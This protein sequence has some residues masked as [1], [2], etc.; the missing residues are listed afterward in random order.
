[1]AGK[2]DIE[3]LFKAHY[4]QLLR[5]ALGLLHDNDLARDIVHDVFASILD[6]DCVSP[7]I[8][9]AYLLR[10]VR[11]RCIN[12]IRDCETR[13]RIAHLYFLDNDMYESE[14][15]NDEQLMASVRGIIRTDLSE[16][17]RRVIELRFVQGLQFSEVA[18]QMGISET[19]VFRHL[20]HALVLIRQKLNQNG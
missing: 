10:A 3:Q 18:R 2:N 19:A 13:Q 9:A 8:S 16:K 5:L 17:A 12:H 20:R 14:E 1:M 6:V 4:E 15:G 11:N 7:G